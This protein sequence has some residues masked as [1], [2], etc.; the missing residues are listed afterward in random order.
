MIQVG[1]DWRRPGLHL[2]V[3]LFGTGV[4][5]LLAFP[6]GVL[7]AGLFWIPGAAEIL[8]KIPLF[9]NE[10]A[11]AMMLSFVAMSWVLGVIDV[12][13]CHIHAQ[14]TRCENTELGDGNHISLR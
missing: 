12:W 5:F 14:T 1:G 11:L 7:V 2:A 3:W 6:L 9:R 4:G 13:H 10:H 8:V